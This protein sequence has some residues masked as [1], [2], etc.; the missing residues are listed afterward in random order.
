[1][2]ALA[3]GVVAAE[4]A[5]D[6]AAASAKPLCVAYEGDSMQTCLKRVEVPDDDGGSGGSAT[7]RAAGGQTG[8]TPNDSGPSNGG[9]SSGGNENTPASELTLD[10]RLSAGAFAD[11]VVDKPADW[12]M[13]SLYLFVVA[14][15]VDGSPA[16][17]ALDEVGR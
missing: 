4:Q 2:L 1:M 10:E 13:R 5:L 15:S 16:P 9:E 11:D 14:N 17:T 7:S 8:G 12:V 6:T 3:S